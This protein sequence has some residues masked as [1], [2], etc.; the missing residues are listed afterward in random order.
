MAIIT[1]ISITVFLF[2]DET[3]IIEEKSIIKACY[4]AQKIENA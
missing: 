1:K 2:V 4:N 3:T